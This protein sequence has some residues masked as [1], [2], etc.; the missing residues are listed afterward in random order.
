MEQE[1]RPPMTVGS[2]DEN[3]STVSPR[4]KSSRMATFTT[5]DPNGGTSVDE[6]SPPP[7]LSSPAPPSACAAAFASA[8]VAVDVDQNRR[9]MSASASPVSGSQYASSRKGSILVS[10][11]TAVIAPGNSMESGCAKT[12]V[13]FGG[14]CMYACVL[15]ARPAG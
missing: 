13:W 4:T 9:S 6:G 1:S 11:R 14:K 3:T 8:P 10:T 5:A 7:A 12:C 15:V 2:R